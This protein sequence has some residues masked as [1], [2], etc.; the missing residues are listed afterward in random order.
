MKKEVAIYGYGLRCDD[1]TKIHDPWRENTI[2][3]FVLCH[4]HTDALRT[5]AIS[6]RQTITTEDS[7]QQA[8]GSCSIKLL[9][10]EQSTR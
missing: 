9:E 8:A 5:H 2:M 6:S 10:V 7:R 4:A 1:Q 3:V